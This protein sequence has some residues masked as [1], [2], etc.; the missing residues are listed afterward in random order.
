MCVCFLWNRR[1][2]IDSVAETDNRSREVRN[3]R[4]GQDPT[5]QFFDTLLN[6]DSIVVR[7]PIRRNDDESSIY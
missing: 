3:Q 6:I 2:E 1:S 7:K 5:P 4:T